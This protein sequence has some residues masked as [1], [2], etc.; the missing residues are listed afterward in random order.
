METTSMI[1]SGDAPWMKTAVAFVTQDGWLQFLEAGPVAAPFIQD[2][3]HRLLQQH[4][5]DSLIS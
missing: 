1:V 2:Q 5:F 4:F 3:L